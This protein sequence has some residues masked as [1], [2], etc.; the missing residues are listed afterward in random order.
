MRAAWGS[1]ARAQG[2]RFLASGALNTIVTYALYCVLVAFLHPQVAY[3]IV[4][5][6]GIVVAYVLNSRYVFGKRVRLATA[7]VYPLVYAAQY[8]LS[9]LLVGVLMRA[10]LGPRIALGIALALVMPLSFVLN[11][12]VLA[13]SGPKVGR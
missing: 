3:A 5:A 6:L 4:F 8:A 7:A 10:G 13:R 2:I 1:G 11:R 12:L 9:A